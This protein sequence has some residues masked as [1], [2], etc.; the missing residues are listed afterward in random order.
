MSK[1][2]RLRTYLLVGLVSLL[3]IVA[4]WL[5]LRWFFL[6]M[7]TVVKQFVP[8]AVRHYI[9]RPGGGIV[10]GLLILL[11][12]GFVVTHLGGRG[13]LNWFEWILSRTPVVRSFYSTARLITDAMFGTGSKAFREVVLIE[14]PGKDLFTFGFVT[15][16]VGISYNVFVPTTPNPTSGWY[17]IVPPNRVVPL[18]TI[19]IHDATS[20]IMSAGVIQPD[21]SGQDEVEAAI[22]TL[23][24]NQ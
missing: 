19:S 10:L 5:T 1:M 23:R 3:P 2:R 14:Y 24:A 18:K 16:R 9:P 13:I 22:E 8:I 21:K 6:H 11:M 17:L 7:D 4:T 20:L 15:G 12:V